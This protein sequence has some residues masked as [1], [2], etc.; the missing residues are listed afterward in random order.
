MKTSQAGFF[1]DA[2]IWRHA[3]HDAWL[4]MDP[5]EQLKNPVMFVV[6]VGAALVTLSLFSGI[7]A[8]NLQITLWLWFTVFFA[9]W[10]ESLAEGR[11]KAQAEALRRT[12]SQVIA[13]R[14]EDG[15][16]IPASELKT[17]DLVVCEANDI[18]PADGEVIEGIA[19][20]DEAAI[21]GE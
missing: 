13:H 10:A 19:T 15:T 14:V 8:F 21:T 2:R 18:I 1:Q 17:G 12:R 16:N 11:G 6:W 4:R 3:M 7:T 20:V 9:N 5:R